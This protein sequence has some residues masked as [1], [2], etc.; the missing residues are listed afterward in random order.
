MKETREKKPPMREAVA[1]EYH[2]SA[3]KVI[4]AGKGAVAENII[5]KAISH[6][7]PIHADADLAHTLNALQIGQEIPPELYTVVA[8]ILLYVRDVDKRA[9]SRE[10]WDNRLEKKLL[11]F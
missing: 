3:P 6:N 4:A 9:G 5:E 7:V 2:E 8:Q 10:I 11:D 1:L